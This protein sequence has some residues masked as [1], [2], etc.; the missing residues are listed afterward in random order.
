MPSWEQALKPEEIR[1]WAQQMTRARD[2]VPLLQANLLAVHKAGITVAAATDAGNTG[3]LHGASMHRELALMVG[4]G[5][6][7]AEALVCATRN[8][9]ILMK[10]EKDLG[11]LEPGKLADLVVL[12]G[13]PLAH[14]ATPTRTR[15]VRT[16]GKVVPRAP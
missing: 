3:T 14:T 13:A 12:D 16:G 1:G 11:T 5:L 2:R 9:A 4:A 6:S 7:P 15:L 10:R 8:G